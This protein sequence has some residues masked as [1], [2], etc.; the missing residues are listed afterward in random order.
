MMGLQLSE[1]ASII[2]GS[3][4]SFIRCIKPNAQLQPRVFHR[5]KVL[6][7]LKCNSVFEACKIMAAGF[8]D[9]MPFGEVLRL[10]RPALFRTP[11]PDGSA[12]RIPPPASDD[13]DA[14]A[15]CERLMQAL[16]TIAPSRWA[17][18]RNKLFVQAGVLDEL[19]RLRASARLRAAIAIQA[20]YRVVVARRF[21]H[22][23]RRAEEARRQ[24]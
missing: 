18:G 3:N 1:L 8:A 19:E 23:L 5:E 13:D 9:R 7:Q 24:K 10:F 4:P 22:D 16:A 2:G 12:S 20:S 17:M 6:A 11:A 21:M 15:G 14:R